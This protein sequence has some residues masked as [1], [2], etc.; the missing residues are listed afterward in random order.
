LALLL[1]AVYAATDEFHQSFVPG[2]T[3]SLGDV[4]IDITGAFVAL[5]V[6]AAWQKWR[7][8]AA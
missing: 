1:A 3:A 4:L 7:M 5:A 2:R 8:P 6:A